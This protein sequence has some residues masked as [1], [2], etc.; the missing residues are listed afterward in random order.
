M[1]LSLLSG[2]LVRQVREFV[3]DLSYRNRIEREAGALQLLE[4][5]LQLARQLHTSLEDV[6]LMVSGGSMRKRTARKIGRPG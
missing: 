5:K 4:W 3:K 2:Q 6:D 1:R